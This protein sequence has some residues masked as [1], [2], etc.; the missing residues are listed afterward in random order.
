MSSAGDSGTSAAGAVASAGLGAR[1]R[2]A[3]QA[4]NLATADVARQLKLYVRQVEALEAGRFHDLPGP[5]FVRGFIRNYARLLKLDAEE[6]LQAAAG[7]LPQSESRPETPPSQDIPFPSAPARRWPFFAVGVAG[8]VLLLAIYDLF[9]GEEPRTV[10]TGRAPE[11]PAP[12]AQQPETPGP[13]PQSELAAT[14]RAGDPT[15]P[16]AVSAPIARH[17]PAATPPA[18][19][20]EKESAGSPEK[21]EVRLVF[22]EESWVEIR[23]RN[24]TP[25]FSQLNAAGTERRVSG[26]PP[27]SIIVGNAQGVRMTYGGRPVDLGLHTKMD[28]ARLKLE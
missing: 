12:K 27:L 14:P 3:R 8:V 22:D 10:A 26:L 17:A 15:G 13:S 11:A 1:L 18:A 28:V 4:Q 2:Q 16:A 19:P 24:D 7:S 25:I 21:R 23:D 9:L 6:L 5:V 20:Q